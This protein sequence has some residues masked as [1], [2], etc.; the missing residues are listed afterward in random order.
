MGLLRFGLAPSKLR[1]LI[2]STW[3]VLHLNC[4]S[5]RDLAG[6]V[7]KWSWTIL[8]CRPAYAIFTSV[9]RFIAIAKD[10]IFSL[11][12]SV[13]NELRCVI[14]IAPLLHTSLSQSWFSEN[15][16]QLMHLYQGWG[17]LHLARVPGQWTTII[18]S[19][20]RWSEHINVLEIRAVT[21]AVNW[22]VSRPSALNTR[23]LLLSDSQVAI[24]A[25]SKGRSSSFQILASLRSLSALLLAG[26]LRLSLR[27]ISTDLNPADRASRR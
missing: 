5:G 10:R 20:F 8:A 13:R 17:W 15:W 6:L 14:D 1:A 18:S 11:W 2:A 12:P 16:W 19:K 9:Y 3:R 22:L 21:A 7:G 24:G 4:I 25:I 23:I 26:M 27:W